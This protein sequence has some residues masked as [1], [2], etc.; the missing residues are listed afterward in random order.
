M[1]TETEIDI[2]IQL[3]GAQK[4]ENKL[5]MFKAALKVWAKLVQDL[6]IH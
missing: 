6:L 2:E 5:M 4:V 1:A 3:S